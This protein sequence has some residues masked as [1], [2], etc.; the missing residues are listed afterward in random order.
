MTP[1]SVDKRQTQR[2]RHHDWT[3]RGKMLRNIRETEK[4]WFRENKKRPGSGK[5]TRTD[6]HWQMTTD[7]NSLLW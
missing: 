1:K 6:V 5:G 4:F 2:Q 7:K 3:A